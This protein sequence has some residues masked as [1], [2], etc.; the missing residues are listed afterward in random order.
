[1]QLPSDK[2]LQ[3]YDKVKQPRP[4]HEE[5]GVADTWESPLS[6]KLVRAH[7]TNWHM[8]G[9]VLHCDTEY[10]PFTQVMP[11]NYILTG[12]DD[13]GLPTFKVL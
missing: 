2:E 13:Q 6:E 7:P 5:H 1:M 8:V 11:T 3:W 9:N 12:T 4:S 10:G